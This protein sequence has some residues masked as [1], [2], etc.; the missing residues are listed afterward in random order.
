MA[1][2]YPRWILDIAVPIAGTLGQ[3]RR[4]QTD[5]SVQ[6]WSMPVS[7][8]RHEKNDYSQADTLEVRADWSLAGLDPRLIANANCALSMANG[9][10]D[11]T[12]TWGAQSA[13][14]LRFAGVLMKPKRRWTNEARDVSLLFHDYTSFFIHEKPFVTAGLPDFTQSLSQAWARICDHVGPTDPETG[15]VVSVIGTDLRNSIEFRGG[16]EDVVL[17][18]AV[19]SRVRK[20]RIGAAGP[21]DAWAAWQ[22]CVQMCA[23]ISWIEIDHVVVTTA[24]DYYS[25]SNPPRLIAGQNVVELEEER[26][27]TRSTGGVV[28]ECLNPHTGTV[29]E[30]FSPPLGDASVRKKVLKGKKPKTAD[31]VLRAEDR[32]RIV[33]YG[34]TNPATLQAIAD[35]VQ[36]VRAHQ[37]LVGTLSTVAMIVPS[38]DGSG[39]DLLSLGA[40]DA[41]RVEVDQDLL[42]QLVNYTSSFGSGDEGRVQIAMEH[43]YDEGP[44][45]VL[46][47]NLTSYAALGCTF[48][49]RTVDLEVDASGDEPSYRMTIHYL[50]KITAEGQ[51]N[52]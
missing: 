1:F 12:S 47:A 16:A 25:E 18:R 37:E 34:V 38:T 22:Q 43:G 8:F 15:E 46:V 52:P 31:Q 49:V 13:K 39:F 17:G 51:A 36:T 19:A 4:Q 28:V 3:R 27:A 29:L 40:G 9:S 20:G 24:T 14:T 30:A 26:D 11:F 32:E 48:L 5:D 50:N 2:W 41:I 33:I 7:W 45:R 6:R 21:I 44:A 42:T 23:Y 10:A 35:L